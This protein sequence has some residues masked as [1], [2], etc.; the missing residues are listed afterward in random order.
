MWC[1]HSCALLSCSTRCMFGTEY[2]I[3]G[4]KKQEVPLA[5]RIARDDPVAMTRSLGMA[6]GVFTVSKGVVVGFEPT[7]VRA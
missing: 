2:E 7:V 6:H 5:A 1:R 3:S 4:G